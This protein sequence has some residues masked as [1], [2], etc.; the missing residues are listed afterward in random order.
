MEKA[1]NIV[2]RIPLIPTLLV[3]AAVGV[4]AD[5]AIALGVAAVGADGAI[6]VGAA[7]DG[8]IALGVAAIGADGVITLGLAVV[9]GK[10]GRLKTEGVLVPDDIGAAE[11]L[12]I[13]GPVLDAVG[14]AA[15]GDPAIGDV[16]AKGARVT[17]ELGVSR[18]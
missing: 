14:I 2:K 11:G 5:G 6:A 13:G 1:V 8:V 16:G 17:A 10:V 9:G 7:A 15:I 4:M 3:L 12:A 18:G